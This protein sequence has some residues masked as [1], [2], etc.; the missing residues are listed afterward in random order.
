M[1]LESEEYQSVYHKD[2]FSSV[3]KYRMWVG[4]PLGSHHRWALACAM[5]NL[6]VVCRVTEYLLHISVLRNVDARGVP[7]LPWPLNSQKLS[8][9]ADDIRIDPNNPEYSDITELIMVS[10]R[11][12]QYY[13]HTLFP[14]SLFAVY[15]SRGLGCT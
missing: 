6:Y 1:G 8:D 12:Y 10:F 5:C 3:L 14:L 11:N 4:S 9:W 13:K 2:R 7:G 15:F